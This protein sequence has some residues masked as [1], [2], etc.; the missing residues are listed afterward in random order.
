[1][2]KALRGENKVC[3]LNKAIYGLRQAGRCWH[4]KLS[5]TLLAFGAR[6]SSADPC[7][8]YKGKGERLTLI[9]VY[10]DDILVA[11]KQ[12][13]RIN[14]LHLH[15]SKNFETRNLGSVKHCLGMEFE[16]TTFEVSIKQQGYVA[17]LLH[18]F[19]MREAKPVGTPL[20]PGMKLQ[21]SNSTEEDDKIYPYQE[22]IGSLMY[23]AI[24]T[25]PDIAYAVTYLSQFNTC[26]DSTHWSAAKRILRYLKGTSDLGL[27]YKKTGRPVHGYVDAD[28]GNCTIDRRSFTGYA[29][30]LSGCPIAWISRKQRTVALSSVEAEYMALTEA[31]KEAYHLKRLLL[32]FNQKETDI[33]VYC[34]SNGAR[35]LAENP[36]FHSRTKHIDVRHHFVRNAIEDRIIQIEYLGTNDMAADALTIGLS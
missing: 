20:E 3:L 30:V 27:T 32:E 28:W 24:C 12:A 13:S 1:M 25:R 9:V 29:F 10:V 36:V 4:D 8:F 14:E 19:E 11:S 35:K 2:L 16:Q 22:L 6:R 31:A 21:K 5:E 26:H 15:L 17:N 18:R 23:L 7:V 34:D 33:K